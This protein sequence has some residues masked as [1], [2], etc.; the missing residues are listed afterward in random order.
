MEIPGQISAE[1]NILS[2]LSFD[3]IISKPLR[4]PSIED[5]LIAGVICV[6]WI[7]NLN[8]VEFIRDQVSNF[9]RS[10]VKN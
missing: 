7:K 6:V 3:N 10:G 4:P 8:G 5:A 9:E 1:I 2:L